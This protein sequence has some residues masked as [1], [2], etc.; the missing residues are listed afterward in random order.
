MKRPEA[1][2]DHESASDR[3]RGAKPRRSFDKSA[4]AE[5]NQE[6]LQA[7]V[8]GNSSDRFLHDFELTGFNGDVVKKNCC[9]HDPGNLQ[10]AK[11]DTISET[12]CSQYPRHFEK[13]DRHCYRGRGA[14]DGA[15]VRLHFQAGE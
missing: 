13:Y 9:Q 14:S 12:R 4:E 2:S 15:P 10:Q 7:T 8:G 11:G 3:N 1:Q 5:C 6:N